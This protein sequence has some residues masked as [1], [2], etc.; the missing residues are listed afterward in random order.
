MFRKYLVPLLALAGVAVA[1]VAVVRDTKTTPSAPPA[2]EPPQPPYQA[3]VAGAG[4]VQAS[5]ENICIGTQIAGIVAKIYVQVG[6]NLKA[7]DP[8]FIGHFII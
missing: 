7:G 2:A 3:F 8:L 1:I 4:I 5:S 6:S